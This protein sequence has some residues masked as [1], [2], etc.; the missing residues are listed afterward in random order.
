[1]FFKFLILTFLFISYLNAYISGIYLMQNDE[2]EKENI[3][4]IFKK[5]DKFYAF[6]FAR[7]DGSINEDL[8]SK[9]PNK[10]LQNRKI[11][12]SVFLELECK[13][14]KQCYGEIYSFNKAK[15]YP[16]KAEL[17]DEILEVKIDLLFAPKI[18]FKKLSQKEALNFQDKRLNIKD[19]KTNMR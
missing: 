2:K 6:G 16:V 13:N 3:V 7:S 1:M 17:K 5:E 10:A 4:E 15:F 19:I 11:R 9:N 14:E 8:D 12:G 18:K